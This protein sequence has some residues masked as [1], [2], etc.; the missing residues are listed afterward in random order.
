[1]SREQI[2]TLTLSLID[3]EQWDDA[4]ETIRAFSLDERLPLL[5]ERGLRRVLAEGR[6][7]AVEHWVAW[8]DE[9]HVTTPEIALA[10][11]ETYFRRGAWALSESLQ[12]TC[13]RSV[14][15]NELRAQ[16]HLCAGSSAHLQDEVDRAWNHYDG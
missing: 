8:A 2:D 16:A 3:G 13:A 7:A 9:Q 15:A 6:L 14:T 4:F 10:Q 1:M 12:H 11:A 5:I